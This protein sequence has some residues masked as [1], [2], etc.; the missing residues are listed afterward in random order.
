MPKAVFLRNCLLSLLVFNLMAC[1][2][3]QPVDVAS[4]MRYPPANVDVGSLVKVTTLNDREFKFRVT[5]MDPTGLVGKYGFILYE[6]MAALKVETG[7]SG[8][9]STAKIIWGILGVAALIALI[10]SADTVAICSGTPCIE[11]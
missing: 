3:M 7:R 5:E 1:S 8:D 4:A 10:D 11:P 2:T 9:G 6:D